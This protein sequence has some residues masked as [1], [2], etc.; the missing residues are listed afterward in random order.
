MRPVRY[1][2]AV[3]VAGQQRGKRM[4]AGKIWMTLVALSLAAPA[5][6]ASYVAKRAVGA[7]ELDLRILTDDTRGRLRAENILA[8][9]ISMTVA[10]RSFTLTQDN[11][12]VR[13]SGDAFTANPDGMF[14]DFE[15]DGTDSVAFESFDFGAGGYHL[16]NGFGNPIGAELI[17]TGPAAAFV[18]IARRDDFGVIAL[19]DVAPPLPIPEPASWALMVA[20]F[21]LAGAGM[22][23]A[24]TSERV[25]RA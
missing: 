12:F 8:W 19:A 20:G 9:T 2:D 24:K 23:R 25:V 6:A 7:G 5:T 1:D 17:R 4:S 3:P 10:G 22:R 11:S 14:F 15:R 18:S 16:N 21:G 13:I